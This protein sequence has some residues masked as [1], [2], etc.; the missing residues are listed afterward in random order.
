MASNLALYVFLQDVQ[1]LDLE[2]CPRGS[3]HLSMC[4]L[5]SEEEEEAVDKKELEAENEETERN[6]EERPSS[7]SL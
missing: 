2:D 4:S 1:Y 7:Q 3:D 6:Q 5:S